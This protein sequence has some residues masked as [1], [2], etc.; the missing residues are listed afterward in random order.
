MYFLRK[1]PIT[2][3]NIKRTFSHHHDS[4][5]FPVSSFINH[6]DREKMEETNKNVNELVSKIN[7]INFKINK[8]DN[9]NNYMVKYL[10]AN[11]VLI[12]G[13][14]FCNFCL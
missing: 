7:Q 4:T 10:I 6:F 13:I 12:N 8:M 2:I 5:K 11:F 3:S 9:E 14:L 1:R